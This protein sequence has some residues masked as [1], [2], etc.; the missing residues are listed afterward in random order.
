MV[1]PSCQKNVVFE[2]YFKEAAR[3]T[4]A[5]LLQVKVCI[6]Q[7]VS[8]SLK[9]TSAKSECSKINSSA[10]LQDFSYSPDPEQRE[11]KRSSSDKGLIFL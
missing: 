8:K 6:L 11:L 7:A 5:E 1:L 4:L 2:G 10:E 9:D 3:D